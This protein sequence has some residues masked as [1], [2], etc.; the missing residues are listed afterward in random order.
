MN[1]L[2]LDWEFITYRSIT[3][4]PHVDVLQMALPSCSVSAAYGGDEIWASLGN[5]PC[6]S[7]DSHSSPL[8]T[9]PA[10]GAPD[11][12]NACFAVW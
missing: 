2:D 11:P 1:D 6:T 8:T 5:V 10:N 3:W 7:N 12:N 9:Q 4:E